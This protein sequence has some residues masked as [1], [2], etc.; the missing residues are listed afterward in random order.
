MFENVCSK[1]D[2]RAEHIAYQMKQQN[3]KN[4]GRTEEEKRKKEEKNMICFFVRVIDRGTQP[5]PRRQ[6]IVS[7]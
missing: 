5:D 3:R 2:S 6:P 4:R 1:L 7:A